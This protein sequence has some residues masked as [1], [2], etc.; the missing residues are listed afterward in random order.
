MS[1]QR[2][3]RCVD[4]KQILAR[5]LFLYS[6]QLTSPHTNRYIFFHPL[7]VVCRCRDPQLISL[8]F[9][10][11]SCKCNALKHFPF[12]EQTERLTAIKTRPFQTK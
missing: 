12:E 1:G 9:E 10:S 7:E 2:R 4:I 3:R 8:Q 6:D 5:S 11:Q